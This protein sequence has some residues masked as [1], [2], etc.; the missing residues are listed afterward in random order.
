MWRFIAV[1]FAFMGFAFY[2]LSGGADYQ[3]RTQPIQTQ[4]KLKAVRPVARPGSDVQPEVHLAAV[5]TKS[6]TEPE[7]TVSRAALSFADL[8]PATNDPVTLMLATARPV[9]VPTVRADAAQ[10]EQATLASLTGA[11]VQADEGTE[12]VIASVDIRQIKG[13]VV[14]MRM[15]PGTNY[16]RVGKLTGGTDVEVLQDPGNGWLK[17]RVVETRRVGWMADFLVTAAN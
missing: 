2:E 9:E 15:G 13:N 5:S 6:A 14:N 12:E 8:A 1:T 17:I 7:E 3:P 4:A 11:P 10:I 16:N